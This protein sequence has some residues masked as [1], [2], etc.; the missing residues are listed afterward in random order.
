[1]AT[2]TCQVCGDEFEHHFK[3]KTCSPECANRARSEAAEEQW[4]ERG[5]EMAQAVKDAMNRP[6]VREHMRQTQMAADN[7]MADRT[8]VENPAW[9]GGKVIF[10]C[11]ICGTTFKDYPS[12]D[13]VVCS[14]ECRGEWVSLNYSGE[15]ASRWE[16]GPLVVECDWCGSEHE[17]NNPNRDGHDFCSRECNYAWRSKN[18]VGEAAP[19]WKGGYARDRDTNWPKL[20]AKILAACDHRCQGCGRHNDD[21]EEEYGVGL[22]AH[23]ILPVTYFT[24]RGLPPEAADTVENGVALCRDCHP[25]WEGVP[26]RPE[27]TD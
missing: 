12:R 20:R 24:S 21:H 4:A 25:E 27:L 16:G 14:P 10:E 13:R 15:D 8:G 6:E 19:N 7:S 9:K 5:D 1:M 17:T 11:A 26:V 22:H 23:H 18:L 2:Y 3:K